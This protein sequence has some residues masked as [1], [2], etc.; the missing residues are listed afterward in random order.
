MV[1]EQKFLESG[2][3]YMEVD[4]MHS[5]TERAQKYVP[6]Y[7]MQDWLT[8]FRMARTSRSNKKAY[9]V[10]ELKF[11]DFLDLEQLSKSLIKNKLKN[12]AGEKVNWL[13][14][15]CFRYLKCKPG[16]LQYRYDHTSEYKE[17][18]VLGTGKGRPYNTNNISD[19]KILKAYAKV[20]PI[21][22][23]KKKDLLNLCKGENPPIPEEF[24]RYYKSL[25]TS[26]DLKDTIPEPSFE[27]SDLESEEEL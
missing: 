2:H 21:T 12:T 24:H 1:I 6:V 4:S 27:D 25:P 3:S 5:A 13:K 18:L 14:V 26:I 9:N 19:L 11:S 23:K 7:T 22:D 20:R 8:I 10:V 17:I 15:K 16:V